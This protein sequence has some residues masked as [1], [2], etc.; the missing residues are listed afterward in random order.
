LEISEIRVCF[1]VS[2]DFRLETTEI[3]VCWILFIRAKGTH[4]NNVKV[5]HETFVVKVTSLITNNAKALNETFFVE[6][7]DSNPV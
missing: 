4:T 7:T 2:E 3:Q 6:V 1:N 5:L